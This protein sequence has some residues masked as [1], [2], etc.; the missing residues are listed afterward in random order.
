MWNSCWLSV[1]GCR[2][3]V[4]NF[5]IATGIPTAYI[6]SQ[7]NVHQTHSSDLLQPGAENRERGTIVAE[8]TE[9]DTILFTIKDITG[10]NNPEGYSYTFY[11]TDLSGK[12]YR[13][14]DNINA[15]RYVLEKGN[16]KEGFYFIELRGANIYRGK[17]VIE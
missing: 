4:P 14:V 11:I 12:V 3:L 13:I 10:F 7:L 15:S 16:M 6:Q 2:L 1:V 5:Y 8:G 17:I 9:Q